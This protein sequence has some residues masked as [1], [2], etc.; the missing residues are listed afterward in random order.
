M[1]PDAD[2]L[3]T[4]LN[5]ARAEAA[6]WQRRL[7][8]MQ[9]DCDQARADLRACEKSHTEWEQAYAEL[10]REHRRLEVRVA[11]AQWIIDTELVGVA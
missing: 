4:D 5:A 1:P 11:H 10:L 2:A 8:R 3:L 9:T 7:L 6:M